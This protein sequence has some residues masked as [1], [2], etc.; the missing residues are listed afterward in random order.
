M[1]KSGVN[2]DSAIIITSKGEAVIH[3]SLAARLYW[4]LKYF[5]F[6]NVALLDGGTAQWIKDKQKVKFGKSR[7][8]KGNF[9]ATAERKEILATTDDVVKLSQGQGGGQL[10]DSR[11]TAEYLGLTASGKFVAPGVKGHVEGAKSFPVDLVSNAMGPATVYDK[12]R[13]Q[14]VAELMGLD[15]GKPT[16]TMC[17]SG[18]FASTTWFASTLTHFDP[19]VLT[20]NDPPGSTE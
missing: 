8:E 11:S 20:K 16:I 2:G 15:T 10:V 6:D 12:E 17:N 13:L 3:T 19:P 14:T 18:V 5:G 7:A 4:T 1:Q 9:K